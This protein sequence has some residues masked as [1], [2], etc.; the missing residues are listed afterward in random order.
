VLDVLPSS[1]NAAALARAPAW[2]DTTGLYGLF[3]ELLVR[4]MSKPKPWSELF[5]SLRIDAAS[6]RYGIVFTPRSGSTWLGE[7]LHSSGFLGDPKEFFNQ[8]AADYAIRQSR[9][10]NVYAYYEYLKIYHQT[11]GVFG[12]EVAP[13]QLE[14]LSVQ[15]YGNLFDD[16]QTWFSLRRKDFVAQAV[17]LYRAKHTGIYHSFQSTEGVPDAPYD[18]S[19]IA[20]IALNIVSGERYMRQFF[21]Q[22]GVT[23]LSLWY[24][25]VTQWPQAQTLQFF[26]RHIGLDAREVSPSSPGVAAKSLQKLSNAA[27]AALVTRFNEENSSFVDYW[28]CHRGEKT[29]FQFL[30][31]QPRYAGLARS[32]LGE[33]A[34]QLI[35]RSKARVVQPQG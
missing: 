4:S 6:Q 14:A 12:F 16:V 22:R 21:A 9:S 28:H 3:D 1:L 26:A 34:A 8:Q 15:G 35:A 7:L 30:I 11:Q 32:V 10:D 13:K 18:A 31:E 20:R 25:E 2:R 27:S 5:A 17:S 23:E 33:K 24:E 29:S 19:E